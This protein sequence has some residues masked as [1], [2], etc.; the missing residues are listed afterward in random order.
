MKLLLQNYEIQNINALITAKAAGI[1]L[2]DTDL[3]ILDRE[4]QKFLD[5]LKACR[6]LEELI[7][8]LKRS[9]YKAALKGADKEYEKTQDFRV[10]RRGLSAYYFQKLRTLKKDGDDLL[11][12]LIEW[13]NNIRNIM[14]VLRIKRNA[15]NEDVQ[16]FLVDKDDRLAKELNKMGDFAR[17]L[18]RIGRKYP[19]TLAAVEECQKT[20]SLIPLEIALERE[21]IRRTM[22]MLR[23]AVLDFAVVLGYLYLK[24]E[25]IGTIRKIAYAKQYDFTD[26]LKGMI[27]SFNA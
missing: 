8:R 20:D 6:S 3:V 12:K 26:E 7:K 9:E 5:K 19:R 15:P 1:E 17:M 11:W 4:E 14:I 27:Y 23:V 13:R 25:E 22:R 18:E 21:F 2:A 24:E 16:K 10:Y